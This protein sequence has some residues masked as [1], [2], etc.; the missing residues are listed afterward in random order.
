MKKIILA[1]FIGIAATASVIYAQSIKKDQL[2]KE[3]EEFER[4]AEKGDTAAM[5]KLLL[6]YD[7]NTPVYLDVEEVIEVSDEDY[8]EY[9]DTLAYE[10]EVPC[11]SI[12]YTIDPELYS[13]YNSRLDYWIEKGLT[14]NDPVATYIKGMRLYYA[15]ESQALEYLSRSADQGNPQAAL[16]CGSAYF[17]QGQIKKAIK[18]QTIAYNAG[19]PSAGWHLAMCI[20]ALDGDADINKAIEYMRQSAFH[21]YPEAVLEM[22]RIEPANKVWQ[23]KADSLQINFPDFPIIPIE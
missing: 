13:L 7:D 17:N 5:H 12:R 19:I 10:G 16:F 6:F 9:V 21:N 1:I 8:E 2:P 3:I 4:L 11:N 15:D 14:L 22:K 20:V 23:H 18:Y